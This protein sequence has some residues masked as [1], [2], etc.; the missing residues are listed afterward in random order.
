MNTQINATIRAK[1]LAKEKQVDLS[2][3]KGS[4]TDGLITDL[5]VK[6]YLGISTEVE[7]KE[8]ETFVKFT[9][10]RRVTAK[11]L[12]ESQKNVAQATVRCDVDMSSVCA[13]RD[14]AKAKDQHVTYNDAII[15][16][17]AKA[18][19]D[20]P[21]VNSEYRE[22]GIILKSHVN[23]GVA[24][25]S[26][27]GLLVPVIQNAEQLSLQEIIAESRR[28]TIA[29]REGKLRLDE[30]TGGTFTISN[31][32]VFHSQSGEAII[33]PPET[34]I[35]VFG[36]V[37]ERAVVKNHAITIAPML[38]MTITYDH[39]VL[40]GA[41]SGSFMDTLRNYLQTFS[42]WCEK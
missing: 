10:A 39:R 2:L 18:L 20:H 9:P 37:E 22:N 24:A 42:E 41:D 25:A 21:K 23:L 29:A 3:V 4:G 32:G 14:T 28:L 6:K 16:C 13:Y 1:E 19:A 40:D 7:L 8:G 12:F 34:G 33:N 15:M 35:I 27:R 38:T 26:P 11:R 5:D 30:M 31:M 36:C 17:T